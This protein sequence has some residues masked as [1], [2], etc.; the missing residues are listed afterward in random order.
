MN[1]STFHCLIV[2]WRGALKLNEYFGWKANVCLTIKFSQL[3]FA[4]LMLRSFQNIGLSSCKHLKRFTVP[5]EKLCVPFV[6]FR[7]WDKVECTFPCCH[8]SVWTYSILIIE[9]QCFSHFLW[10][11]DPNSPTFKKQTPRKHTKLSPKV[12]TVC[13]GQNETVYN[14]NTIVMLNIYCKHIIRYMLI[15]A[16]HFKF[17]LLYSIMHYICLLDRVSMI[18]ENPKPR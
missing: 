9:N 15:S 16:A 18:P 8:Q 14:M 10:A 17:T 11:T 6:S 3:Q 2:P 5:N 12:S 13:P 4:L 1:Q 7:A